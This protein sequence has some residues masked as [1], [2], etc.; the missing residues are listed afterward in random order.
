MKLKR[1]TIEDFEAVC[2]FYK[3]VVD[4]TPDMKIYA[5]WIYGLHP[6]DDIIRSYIEQGCM[7]ISLDNSVINAAVA[8]TPSQG[9][10]YRPVTWGI[11]LA[12]EEVAV[13]HILCTDPK[14]QRHGLGKAVMREVIEFARREGK[15][16]VRLDALEGND[17]AHKLY[18]D[19]G[20]THHGVKNWYVS[21]LGHAD[22]HLYEYVL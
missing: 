2:G 18:Q 20:F 3:Y 11:D 4:A 1:A 8:V 7:Y 19:L 21:N 14:C 16:A 5:R 17:P 6:S 15:K 13:V 22:F 12:D 10:E 9:E